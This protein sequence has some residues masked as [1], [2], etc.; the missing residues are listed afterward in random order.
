MPAVHA[1][2][3][4]VLVELSPDLNTKYR[5]LLV[6]LGVCGSRGKTL[7]LYEHNLWRFDSSRRSAGDSWKTQ[8]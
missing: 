4:D 5:E 7:R 3:K 2:S 6:V 1:I 8:I